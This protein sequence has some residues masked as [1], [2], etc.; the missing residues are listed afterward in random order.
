MRI[1]VGDFVFKKAASRLPSD[2]LAAGKAECYRSITRR[3][4]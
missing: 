3:G 4:T 2:P 1:Y